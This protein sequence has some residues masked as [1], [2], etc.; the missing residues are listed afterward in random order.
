VALSQIDRAQFDEAKATLRM[1]M[2]DPHLPVGAARIR[3]AVEK[4]DERN[5][6]AARKLLQMTNDEFEKRGK[7][8]PADT[9][10]GRTAES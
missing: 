1:L 6:V 8:G 10:E 2:R 3:A 7:E 9:G 4:L 5:A